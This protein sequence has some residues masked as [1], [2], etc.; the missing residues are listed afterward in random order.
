L[1]EGIRIEL[2]N[3]LGYV[4]VTKSEK[5]EKG[6]GGA[7]VGKESKKRNKAEVE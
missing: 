4:G 5:G 1:R 6:K 3:W 7:V 2:Y